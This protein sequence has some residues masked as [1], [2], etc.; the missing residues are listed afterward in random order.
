MMVGFFSEKQRLP[1]KMNLYISGVNIY[2]KNS[3]YS[4]MLSSHPPFDGCLESL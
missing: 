3:E 2:K 4:P 1:L